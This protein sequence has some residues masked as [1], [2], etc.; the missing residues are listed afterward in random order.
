MKT[1]FYLRDD[2]DFPRACIAVESVGDLFYFTW[3]V[4]N[5]LDE[6]SKKR[7]R[8]VAEGR[9]YRTMEFVRKTKSKLADV[10]NLQGDLYVIGEKT[11]FGV[12]KS[13]DKESIQHKILSTIALSPENYYLIPYRLRKLAVK[14]LNLCELDEAINEFKILFKIDNATKTQQPGVPV[15]STVRQR[16][17]SVGCTEVGADGPDGFVHSEQA[18]C[19][20]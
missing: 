3:S 16:D 12:V 8:D 9:L 6:F 13:Q 19:Q 4:W 5:P 1:N 20:G 7:S 2:K 15:P 14:H 11:G 10:Q 18:P 17:V